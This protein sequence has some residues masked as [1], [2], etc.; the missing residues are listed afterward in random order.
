[1]AKAI[2]LD[3]SSGPPRHLGALV[4]QWL[5]EN[6]ALVSV[7][8][9]NAADVEDEID[10]II[11]LDHAPDGFICTTAHPDETI[12]EVV[13]LASSFTSVDKVEVV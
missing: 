1:M 6:V 9:P 2:V 11:I 8:G 13:E 7:V 12:A 5:A 3:I 10:W 4:K